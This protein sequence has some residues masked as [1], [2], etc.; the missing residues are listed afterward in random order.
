MSESSAWEWLGER[1]KLLH[2]TLDLL[3]NLTQAILPAFFLLLILLVPK[4]TREEREEDRKK[5]KKSRGRVW[6]PIE[7]QVRRCGTVPF[8]T[9]LVHSPVGTT[10]GFSQFFFLLRSYKG[11]NHTS[12]VKLLYQGCKYT[13]IHYPVHSLYFN[14]LIKQDKLCVKSGMHNKDSAQSN[15]QL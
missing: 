1:V 8:H 12:F 10:K 9:N 13:D 4:N 15:N 5:S 3:P 11:T 14:G 7:T 6:I 2:S